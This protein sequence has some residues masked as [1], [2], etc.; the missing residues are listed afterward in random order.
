MTTVSTVIEDINNKV[1]TT[2]KGW[3]ILAYAGKKHSNTHMA[4]ATC[5]GC[6]KTTKI[7]WGN[8]KRPRSNGCG[9]YRK[10][11]AGQS[12]TPEY[13]AYVDM[14]SR[15]GLLPNF[16]ERPDSKHWKGRGISVCKEWVDS[17]FVFSKDVG[18]RPSPK[19]TL[20]RIN[21][22]DGYH[23]GNVRWATRKQQARNRRSNLMITYNGD[24]KCLAEWAELYRIKLGT[25]HNRLRYAKW[26]VE[27]ALT[28]PTPNK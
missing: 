26:S 20:D 15:C 27:R 5:A 3:G 1:G 6:G 18:K 14:L 12:N 24:T 28:T 9:C 13:Q 2:F 19:H 11:V 10:T 21:N 7:Q 22:D 16:N 4:W 8:I 25:L 23:K 17:F